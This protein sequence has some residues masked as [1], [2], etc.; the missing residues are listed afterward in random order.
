VRV[1]LGSHGYEPS[2]AP[3]GES[4]TLSTNLRISVKGDAK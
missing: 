1:V 4:V 2:S 3:R